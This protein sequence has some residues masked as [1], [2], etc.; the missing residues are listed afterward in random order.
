MNTPFSRSPLRLSATLL[1]AVML[2]GCNTLTRLS[3]VGQEPNLAAIE[4]PVEKPEYR[5]VRMP[6]P[7]VST[8]ARFSNSLWRPG[9]R[10]FLKDNRAA[11]IG[12]ILTV[13]VNIDDEADLS[14]E[15]TAV[16]D[17]SETLG[18]P[19]LFGYEQSLG[20]ILPEQVNPSALLGIDADRSVRGTG[21]IARDEQI[22]L[23]VAAIVTQILPNGNMVIFGRQ[24]A[25]VNFE[26]R[27]VMVSGVI[28]P[29]DIGSGNT[30][31]HD[32]IA[33]ARIAYGGRGTL[34]DIQQP[35]YGQQVLDI[36]LPF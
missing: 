12:D 30:I 6:M 25:R 16:R 4:N 27:E 18:L 34:S 13:I 26:M 15:T 11:D 2:S 28:R 29:S 3:E 8:Q 20:Q 7:A 1:A 9:A 23:R 31:L 17:N 10:A 33:E 35:R 24:Q 36:L 22:T 5:P 32:Q 19:R 21:D 14:N